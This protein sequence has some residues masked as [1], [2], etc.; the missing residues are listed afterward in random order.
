MLRFINLLRLSIILVIGLIFSA[1]L[2]TR[3]NDPNQSQTVQATQ[4]KTETASFFSPPSSSTATEI[5]APAD[6]NEPAR[7]ELSQPFWI[8]RGKIVESVFLPGAKQVAIAWGS[9]VSLN[10]VETGEEIWFQPTLENL[11]AFDV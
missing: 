6:T 1:C 3:W 9:G 11:I 4:A 8:G 2:Q 7:L 5:P 10:T